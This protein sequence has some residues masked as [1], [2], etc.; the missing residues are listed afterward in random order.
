MKRL[1]YSLCSMAL[2]YSDVTYE[3]GVLSGFVGGQSPGT[4]YENWV[5]HV[6]E[7]IASEGFN[8]YGPD[9]LDIQTNGFGSYR[10]LEEGSPTLE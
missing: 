6:T 3:S 10:K 2:L 8:D 9:W 7:G 1:F 4:S 5:S